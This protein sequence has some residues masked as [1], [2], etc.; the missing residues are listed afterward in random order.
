MIF[1]VLRPLWRTDRS[2]EE[3]RTAFHENIEL[4]LSP[5]SADSENLSKAVEIHDPTR[6]LSF[7]ESFLNLKVSR[8]SSFDQVY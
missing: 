8:E 3:F 7:I 1:F 2:W 6:L 5:F 4:F